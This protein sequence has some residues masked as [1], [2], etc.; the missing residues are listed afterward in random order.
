M[1]A[2][3]RSEPFAAYIDGSWRSG[4]TEVDVIDPSTETH[5]ATVAFADHETANEAVRSANAAQ[6]AW[7]ATPAPSRGDVLRCMRTVL[8]K[9][10]DHL[11][12][13]LVAEGGKPLAEARGEVQF[14]ADY[15]QYMAEWDRRIEG[16]IFPSDTAMERIEAH[17]VALGVV[18]AICPWNYPIAVMFRKVAP[19]LLT[20][21]TV[22]VKP[23][24]VTPL[25]SVAAM[26]LLADELDLPP[27][28]LNL[29]SGGK[30]VGSALVSNPDVDMISMTGHRDSGKAIMAAAAQSMTRVS[31]ELGGK[32]PAIVCADA[33][34]DA[35]VEALVF[36][37]YQHAGQV[38]T[39]VERV[40]VDARVHD[41]F[42]ERLLAAT[43]LLRVGHPMGEV[44]MG[45][46]VSG[47]Q[48]DKVSRAVDRAV[49]D[50]ATVRLGGARPDG[51]EFERGYW[52]AP[53]VLT[54]VEPDMSIMTEEVFGPV[55]PIWRYADLNEAISVANA[56][57]YGL[58]AFVFT[59]DY[60]TAMQTVDRLRCGEIY[61]NRTHGE[62]MQGF[63]VGHGESGIGGED[64]IHGVLEYTQ[65][66]S[67][68]HYY[69]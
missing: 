62:A 44:D 32:A 26:R 37:R 5:V 63:H 13:I 20:G 23:S 22:I 54:E 50:G 66:K 4:A 6:P 43:R 24:E 2:S 47:L 51:A 28:V 40:L 16:Q 42:V 21:N 10:R 25:S 61:V 45:P 34:L 3:T 29:V 33:D 31:L 27:G 15:V 11:A 36:A 7:E 53:T 48:R 1:T 67:V 56:S 60:R 9:H 8:L 17:R 65:L 58:S 64:G 52:Y 59:S 55:L 12:D 49:A 18:A 69:G 41:E 38:C 19:A 68:Y 39:C 30:D 35:T 57:R 46:L 14:A